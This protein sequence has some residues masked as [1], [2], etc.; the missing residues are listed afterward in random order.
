MQLNQPPSPPGFTAA[1]RADPDRL[2]LGVLVVA[3]I[4]TGLAAGFFSTY[5]WS[6]VR[7]LARVDDPTYVSTFQQ[8]NATVRT[9]W[10]AL[11][12]FGAGVAGALAIA[13]AAMRQLRPRITAPIFAATAVYVCGVLVV[14][15]AGNVPL[16]DDLAQSTDPSTF[17][18]ARQAFEQDWNRLNLVRAITATVAFLAA[19]AGL[20]GFLRR[21]PSG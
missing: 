17:A 10:F 7:G 8:I 21:P 15:F 5:Q 13:L 19:L 11:V 3:T 12:F 18:L 16:N 9:P 20:V 14:T 6:V 2:L 1:T 4:T